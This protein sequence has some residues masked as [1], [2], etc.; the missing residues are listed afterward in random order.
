MVS[1]QATGVEFLVVLIL[2]VMCDV[3]VLNVPARW[4]MKARARRSPNEIVSCC[5][6]AEM[7]Q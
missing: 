5:E 2:G 7:T 3:D 1:D 4:G 6:E